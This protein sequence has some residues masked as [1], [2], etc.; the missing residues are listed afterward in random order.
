VIPTL[1]SRSQAIICYHISIGS[2][3]EG[4]KHYDLYLPLVFIQGSKPRESP[5][6]VD[7]LEPYMDAIAL[8]GAGC[9]TDEYLSYIEIQTKLGNNSGRVAF[10]PSL[11][12]RLWTFPV[13]SLIITAVLP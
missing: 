6:I 12:S 3:A 5:Q 13:S 4:L 2:F 10:P 1:S 8:V 9:L 7:Y 11:K